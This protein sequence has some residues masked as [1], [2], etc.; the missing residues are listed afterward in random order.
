[1]F[2]SDTLLLDAIKLGRILRHRSLLL[3]LRLIPFLFS[4]GSKQLSFLLRGIYFFGNCF[5]KP[6]FVTSLFISSRQNSPGSIPLYLLL[7]DFQYSSGKQ[8]HSL[9]APKYQLPRTHLLALSPIRP[10]YGFI[11]NWIWVFPSKHLV[12]RASSLI[13][14]N[15]LKLCNDFNRQPR[16]WF[17]QRC[18]HL[19]CLCWSNTSCLLRQ[20]NNNVNCNPLKR[21][22][23]L[24]WHKLL[25]SFPI[26][27]QH[28][29]LWQSHNNFAACLSCYLSAFQHSL[30]L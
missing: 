26:Y 10:I 3:F 9:Q 12:S 25:S 5:A 20:G 7:L 13:W 6:Q 8:H 24:G 28:C 23:A 11:W 22:N 15:W 27:Y 4:M 17:E 2:F 19:Q 1:M 29:F 18:Y 16:T 30:S 21:H 14:V